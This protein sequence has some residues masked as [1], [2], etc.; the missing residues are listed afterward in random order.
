MRL[1]LQLHPQQDQRSFHNMFWSYTYVNSSLGLRYSLKIGLI[2]F[3]KDSREC[4]LHV[5]LNAEI[6]QKLHQ[7][8]ALSCWNYTILRGLQTIN[9]DTKFV[10]T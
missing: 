1:A 8:T 6:L 4:S 7:N 10:E 3:D 5:V 9:L 2:P